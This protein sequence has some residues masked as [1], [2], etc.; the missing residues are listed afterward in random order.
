[1]RSDILPVLELGGWA[2]HIP[3]N[4]RWQHEKVDK[5]INHERFIKG[6]SIGDIVSIVATI[7]K[8]KSLPEDSVIEIYTDGGCSGNPGPGGWA[9]VLS[10][11]NHEIRKSG[12]VPQTT[13][14][15]M[16]LTAVIQALEEVSS[17]GNVNMRIEV[18]TD[19]K[20]VKNGITS[21]IH[22]WIK[23]GWNTASKQPVKNKEL[24]I[25]L[26]E[27]SDKYNV[28][29]KWVKGHAGNPLNEV[30]DAL[31]KKEMEIFL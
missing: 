3:G 4:S 31:V 2:V 25:K 13:N 10:F 19:S 1:L 8:G 26:K 29:W 30:C 17:T 18:Y 7:E 22:N 5:E 21:W 11:G 14:N 23:N 24:W 15:K 16:E 6:K 12:G 27:L 28:T 9:F 20:Y